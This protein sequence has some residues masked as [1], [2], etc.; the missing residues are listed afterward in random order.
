MWGGGAAPLLTALIPSCHL[1]VL[2]KVLTRLTRTIIFFDRILEEKPL[3]NSI[4]YNEKTQK[5]NEDKF[6]RY[7]TVQFLLM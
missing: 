1:T 2:N 6:R 3:G 5:I 7:A 4:I